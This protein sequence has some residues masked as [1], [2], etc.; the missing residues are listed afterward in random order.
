MTNYEIRK[1]ALACGFT[2][3]L[4]SD[5]TTDLNAYVYRFAEALIEAQAA[6]DTPL[7]RQG[8]DLDDM[9]RVFEKVIEANCAKNYPFHQPIDTE[10][11]M[12]LRSFRGFIG[13]MKFREHSPND[14]ALLR[15]ALEVL[16]SCTPQQRDAITALRA[17]LEEAK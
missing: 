15:Q 3:R 13:R 9:V 8:Y 6:K 16:C 14:T 7:L 4:Q 11:R 5:G 2:E 10:A 17:R 12:A 1:I